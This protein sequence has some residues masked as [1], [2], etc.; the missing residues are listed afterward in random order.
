LLG[1]FLLASLRSLA[2][3]ILASL[4]S[5]GKARPPT[6]VDRATPGAAWLAWLTEQG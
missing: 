2:D 1:Q 4:R 6:S 3:L 5:L